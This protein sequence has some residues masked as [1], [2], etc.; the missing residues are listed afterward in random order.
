M[1]SPK[2]ITGPAVSDLLKEQLK[3]DETLRL[4]SRHPHLLG[5]YKTSGGTAVH[6]F[7]IRNSGGRQKGLQELAAEIDRW[8]AERGDM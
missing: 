2:K 8:I 6:L 1:T 4:V 7:R 5:V 3:S